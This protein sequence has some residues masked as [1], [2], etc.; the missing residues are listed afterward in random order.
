M[1]GG[2]GKF[3]Q[4]EGLVGGAR[5]RYQGEDAYA[6]QQREN[7]TRIPGLQK[8]RFFAPIWVE[9]VPGAIT[10]FADFGTGTVNQIPPQ[11]IATNDHNEQSVQTWINAT[12]ENIPVTPV[13]GST[14]PGYR[15]VVEPGWWTFDCT[16][17]MTAAASLTAVGFW[18]YVTPM[19]DFQA[20]GDPVKNSIALP[21]D[22]RAISTTLGVVSASVTLNVPSRSMLLIFYSANQNPT[23]KSA[24]AV[25]SSSIYFPSYL[26]GHQ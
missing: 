9:Q 21:F 18:L 14:Y 2:R 15:V 17:R 23:L 12:L 5:A 7:E 11:I 22:A 25:S 16:L 10:S 1:P 4:G 13:G 6:S 26:S 8:G 24:A 20:S 19:V 3:G